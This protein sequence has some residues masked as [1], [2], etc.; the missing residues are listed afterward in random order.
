MGEDLAFISYSEELVPYA[1]SFKEAF[2]DGT[3][4]TCGTG[5]FY[6]KVTVFGKVEVPGKMPG[7]MPLFHIF[8]TAKSTQLYTAAFEKLRELVPGFRPEVFMADYERA[9]RS[10][11]T[12][13][14]PGCRLV[15][16]FFHYSNVSTYEIF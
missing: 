16:C 13:C 11:L 8:M 5:C 10:A 15:G 4:T 7:Y 12:E 14:F 6:Q 3:F 9:L 1:S 2:C